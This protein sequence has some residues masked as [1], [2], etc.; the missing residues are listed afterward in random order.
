M[1]TTHHLFA[2]GSNGSG[3]LGIGHHEDVSVPK[4]V[5]L[6]PSPSTPLAL[7]AG[8]NH[9]LLLT[10]SGDLY[11]AGDPS[12]G[13]CGPTSPSQL[14]SPPQFHPVD[15]TPT[16]TLIAAT[17]EASVVVANE[18]REVYTFGMG[19][20]GELGLGPLIVR[21]PRPS[22][23]KGFPPAGRR[24]VDLAASMAHVLGEG[25]G[26]ELAVV[27]APRRIEV[28][29]SAVRAVCGKEFT[30]LF[31]DA[32]EGEFVVLGSDKWGVKTGASAAEGVAGWKD[33]GASWGNVF[34]LKGDGSVVSWGRNDHGQLPPENLPRAVQIAVGSEHALVLTE[35]GD[36]IAWGWGEHGNC[37]PISNAG[38]DAQKKGSI[39][40]S[41]KYVP[42]GAKITVIGAGCATSWVGI[43]M[44]TPP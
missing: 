4:P 1:S 26:A 28:G 42:E 15:L 36:V 40:A 3:Q 37:G 20:K 11:W 39:I 14:S 8:G 31:G 5:L 18:G 13:A 7:A 38:G 10:A 19:Q 23:V 25:E 22:L 43:D 24:V 12:P 9:T 16:A 30:C 41:S 32:E 17:W 21:T 6:P 34:V 2:L 33:V 27:D 35:E 29:F 44:P